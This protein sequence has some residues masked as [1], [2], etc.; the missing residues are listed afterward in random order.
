MAMKKN[1]YLPL[2][3]TLFYFL[4]IL[5]IQAQTQSSEFCSNCIGSQNYCLTLVILSEVTCATE[6][7]GQLILIPVGGQS[8]YT[9]TWQDELGNELGEESII[10][11]LKAGNYTATVTDANGCQIF[12]NQTLERPDDAPVIIPSLSNFNGNSVS[13]AGATDGQI[14]VEISGGQA[15][16]TFEWDNQLDNS[17]M[18]SG[19][20]AGTYNLTVTD[21]SG[22][23]SNSVIILTEPTPLTFNVIEKNDISCAGDED[24]SI[25]VDPKGGISPYDLSWSNGIM[26]EETISELSAGNYTLTITDANECEKDTSI[27]IEE[28]A[29]LT[30]EIT[31]VN[32]I[33]CGDNEFGELNVL[34]TGGV[35][36]YS[37][38]WEDDQ[39]GNTANF[40]NPGTYMVTIT[41]VND[42]TI[43][44]EATLTQE[45]PPLIT[46]LPTE[47][48]LQDNIA[49]EIDYET[50][51][52]SELSW[53]VL[54][55]I[56]ID[57]SIPTYSAEAS[58][59]TALNLTFAILEKRAPGWILLEVVP[60]KNGCIG[61]AEQI[62]IRVN[63]GSSPVFV[64]EVFSPNNDG[65][66]DEWE[67]LLPTSESPDNYSVSV[68]SRNG[69]KVFDANSLS[70]AW[71]G[72]GCPDG[73]YYYIILDKTNNSQYKG[74]VS[75]LR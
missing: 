5:S 63:P 52:S 53:R 57:T 43:S 49:K 17:N 41:D 16:Y 69:Q 4:P 12:A 14:E 42:C 8:P 67:I 18:L 7:N 48:V 35:L 65:V 44:T 31:V 19:L 60:Q 47:V 25:S 11:N 58:N 71:E 68:Y 50:D 72:N 22:C 75:I 10:V 70:A 56:N 74:A 51:I 26:R 24:G 40:Q 38:T 34:A 29:A 73:T 39:F 55:T 1:I 2:F 54:S 32:N 23:R 13:C 21:A 15:P 59:L 3:V 64:T 6:N 27:L 33:P 9:Y 20:G 46:L 62:S 36:P 61:E 66:N 37:I 28:P 30:A 45:L